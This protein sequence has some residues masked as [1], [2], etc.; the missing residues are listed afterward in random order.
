MGRDRFPGAALSYKELKEL[1]R[2]LV[3]GHSPLRQDGDRIV[4]SLGKWTCAE[5]LGRS[6]REGQGK[7][8]ELNAGSAQI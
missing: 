8:H 1:S 7:I 4:R 5:S 3:A 6:S 2:C